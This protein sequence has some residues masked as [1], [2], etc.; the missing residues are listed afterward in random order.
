MDIIIVGKSVTRGGVHVTD[1]KPSFRSSDGLNAS[2]L[3]NMFIMFNDVAYLIKRIANR[4]LVALA[5]LSAKEYYRVWAKN[6]L[7]V[8]DG[9]LYQWEYPKMAR[10]WQLRRRAVPIGLQQAIYTA[11]HATPLAGHVGF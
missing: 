8:E 10:L 9:I 2:K 7:E 6:Q 11:Y 5:K 1:F 4:K 3:I